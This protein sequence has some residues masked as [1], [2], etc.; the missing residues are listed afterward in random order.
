MVRHISWFAKID[1]PLLDFLSRHDLLVSPKI[2]GANLG[3][4][5]SYAGRRLRTLR[6]AG[7]LVQHENGLYELSDLGRQF[8]ADDLSREEVEALDPDIEA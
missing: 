5:R 4:H 7:L 2:V 6:D 8:L 1:Y 3:H